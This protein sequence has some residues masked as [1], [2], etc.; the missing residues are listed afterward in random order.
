MPSHQ[1]IDE[2][3]RSYLQRFNPEKAEGMNSVVQMKLTGE[4]G[5]PYYTEVRDQELSVE[6]GTREAPDATLTTSA[7]NWLEI[8][9]GEANPMQL[10]MQGDLSVDGS[11]P[12]ATK[13]QGAPSEGVARSSFPLRRTWGPSLTR[14]FTDPSSHG[15][16][17]LLCAPFTPSSST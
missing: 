5:S 2:F 9:N 12:A 13:L 17:P 16:L 8:N 15:A 3:L 6:E 10:M 1:T 4:G 11:T 7:E 14:R